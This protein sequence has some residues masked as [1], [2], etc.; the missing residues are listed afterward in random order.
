MDIGRY[1]LS[2]A[3]RKQITGFLADHTE[4]TLFHTPGWQEVIR[5]TYGHECDYWLA[6]S[7]S[8]I[9]GLLALTRVRVSGLGEK[10]IALPYQFHAGQPISESEDVASALAEAALDAAESRGARY[11]EIRSHAP[12][13]HLEGSALQATDP[14]LVLT[15][16]A[17]DG[18]EEKTIRRNHRRGVRSADAAGVKVENGTTLEDLRAFR[19]LLLAE[20]R[21]LG[22][23][24]AGWRFFRG[25]HEQLP[26]CYRLFLAHQ[27]GRL[28]GALLN[29]ED[30]RTVFARYGIYSSPE[31]LRL[32]VPQAL[33]WH[34]IRDA[35]ARGRRTF[36]CGISAKSDE[37]LIRWKEGWGGVTAPVHTYVKSMR[38][39][40]PS[41]GDYLDGYRLAKSVW[42]QLPIPLVDL[43]G[44]LV[45]RWVC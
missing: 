22:V 20:S 25:L 12:A 27:D 7:G 6:R 35:A 34:A 28:L 2:K 45:T 44:R 3:P 33:Y 30:E 39:E 38:A 31:A 19:R 42:R 29:L 8:Q 40:A 37:G 18:L 16:V 9:T 1:Q 13:P 36:S 4:G 23:P 32:H 5:A 17:L 10:H 21:R 26:E 24:Q 14:G 43:G 41:A 15:S 11:L